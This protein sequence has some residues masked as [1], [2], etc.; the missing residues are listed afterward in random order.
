MEKS[1]SRKTAG[2]RARAATISMEQKRDERLLSEGLCK[3]P[4]CKHYWF[5]LDQTF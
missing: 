2:K 5:Y 3:K 1:E 4:D